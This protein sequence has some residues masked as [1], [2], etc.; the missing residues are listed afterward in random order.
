MENHDET[1]MDGRMQETLIEQ[2]ATVGERETSPTLS[3]PGNP[4][5]KRRRDHSFCDQSVQGGQ[6][7]RIQKRAKPSILETENAA[8]E[9]VGILEENDATVDEGECQT[10]NKPTTNKKLTALSSVGRRSRGSEKAFASTAADDA[11]ITRLRN[12]FVEAQADASHSNGAIQTSKRW[13]G[14]HSVI[15]RDCTSRRFCNHQIFLL[16]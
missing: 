11:S 8:M 16:M 13:R 9:N 12:G 4:L 5:S 7:E 2:G 6:E 1:H 3:G 10:D 14:E 15:F